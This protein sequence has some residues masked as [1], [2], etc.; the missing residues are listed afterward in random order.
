MDRKGL[1]CV[2]LR[3]FAFTHLAKA[4]Y[5]VYLNLSSFKNDKNNNNKRSCSVPF[6]YKTKSYTAH[7]VSNIFISATHFVV[8][9]V[10]RH[11]I[12]MPRK[13]NTICLSKRFL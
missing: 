3:C 4:Y 5:K 13:R 1:F 7:F 10:P 9:S 2:L 8:L 12:G 11:N 6:K